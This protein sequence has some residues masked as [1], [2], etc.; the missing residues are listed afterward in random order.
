LMRAVMRGVQHL[1]RPLAA[2]GGCVL[3]SLRKLDVEGNVLSM[4][5][6]R[7]LTDLLASSPNILADLRELNLR[8]TP[9]SSSPTL[10]SPPCAPPVP[11]SP[12]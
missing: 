10:P 2:R 5:G 4:Q 7:R 6:V 8:N 1:S 12:G 9:P 11:A 3:A